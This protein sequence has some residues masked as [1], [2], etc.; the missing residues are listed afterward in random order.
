MLAEYN[1]NHNNG[2]K[3]KLNDKLNLAFVL[4]RRFTDQVAVSLG[5][6]MPLSAEIKSHT[7][8]GLKV[9]LNV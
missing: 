2:L 3:V 1:Q 7:R 4:K 6:T 9:D 8:V 5:A